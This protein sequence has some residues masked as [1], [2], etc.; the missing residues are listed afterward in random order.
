MLNSNQLSFD[1]EDNFED[2]DSDDSFDLNY[3]LLNLNDSQ[4]KRKVI[5]R[6]QSVEEQVHSINLRFKV[7]FK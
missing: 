1:N 6:G 5:N 7:D 2:T 3:P 4:F